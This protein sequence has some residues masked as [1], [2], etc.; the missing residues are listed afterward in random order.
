MND[1]ASIC[2]LRVVAGLD[3]PTWM[4]LSADHGL[5]HWC[6]V[7]LSAPPPRAEVLAQALAQVAASSAAADLRTTL[8]TEIDRSR[9]CRVPL[10]LALIQPDAAP[11]EGQRTSS[12]ARHTLLELAL[13]LKR[14]FD[15]ASHL[16]G[17]RLALIFSG[18]SLAEA[19]RMVG[20]ILRRI[21]S[22]ADPGGSSADGSLLCSAGLAGY[23]GS[24]EFTPEDLLRRAG[25]ALDNARDLGGNRLE[26][27]P[28]ADEG[29]APRDTLVRA[30]EKHFLFTGNKTGGI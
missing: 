1:A 5:E 15:H 16:E 4:G 25:Q 18:A 29:M 7:P 9:T 13:G 3:G 30:S 23:G 2:L 14:S 12:S 11:P 21:R 8:R 19:E 10:A 28:S 26:V 6:A 27:A 22:Q 24:V 17:E 20:T